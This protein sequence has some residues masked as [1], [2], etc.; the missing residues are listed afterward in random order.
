MPDSVAIRTTCS[1]TAMTSQGAFLIAPRSTATGWKLLDVGFSVPALTTAFIR[2]V[3]W[4][5]TYD[6]A[7]TRCVRRI[8]RDGCWTDGARTDGAWLV[9]SASDRGSSEG[10]ASRSPTKRAWHRMSCEGHVGVGAA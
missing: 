9:S 2:W 5:C 4:S 7:G 8:L 10:I 1:T 3:S 6:A